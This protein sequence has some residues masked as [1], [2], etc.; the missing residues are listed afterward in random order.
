M[1][2]VLFNLLYTQTYNVIDKEMLI[3]GNIVLF[4]VFTIYNFSAWKMNRIPGLEQTELKAR[5]FYNKFVYG[6]EDIT[7][8]NSINVEG[9]EVEEVT[10]SGKSKIRHR[11]IIENPLNSENNMLLKIDPRNNP[12]P[13]LTFYRREIYGEGPI[14]ISS[15][16]EVEKEV[17]KVKVLRTKSPGTR[18][19]ELKIK[20][21]KKEQ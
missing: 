10:T 15:K 5:K 20:Q 1:V 12:H 8:F 19:M 17:Q 14:P 11:F 2:F 16:A 18:K 4:A 21:E 13:R 7:S 3:V 6:N 9:A